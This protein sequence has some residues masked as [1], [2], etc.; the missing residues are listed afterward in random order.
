MKI[1]N[2]YKILLIVLAVFI[3][4]PITTTYA[5]DDS[6]DNFINTMG[7][8]LA[9]ITGGVSILGTGAINNI[10]DIKSTGSCDI[11]HLNECISEAIISVIINISGAIMPA[12]LKIAEFFLNTSINDSMGMGF[13]P[14]N[15]PYVAAGWGVVRNLANAALVIGLVIIAVSI[16]LGYQ[17]NQAKKILLNFIIIALLINFTPVI[18][19]FIIDGTNLLTKSMMTGGINDGYSRSISNL[20]IAIGNSKSGLVN[21]LIYA[22]VVTLFSLFAVVIYFLY[23]LLFFG[24]TV[25]L[26][27]LVIVSP[28]AFATKVFPQSK[29]IRNFFP[30]V[31]YWDDWWES[32]VQWCAIGIPA[33]MSIYLANMMIV[34][35]GTASSTAGMTEGNIFGILVGYSLPF[36]FLLAGFMISISSGGKFGAYVGGVATAVGVGAMS[37]IGGITKT[38]EGWEVKGGAAGAVAGGSAGLMTGMMEGYKGAREGPMGAYDVLK[39]SAKGVVGGAFT[40]KGHAEGKNYWKRSITEAAVDAHLA[41][42]EKLFNQNATIR[43]AAEEEIKNMDFDD[44]KDF[45]KY[46]SRFSE[47]AQGIALGKYLE[48][49]PDILS[50]L[51]GPELSR[52]VNL[53]NRF[54]SKQAKMNALMTLADTNKMGDN[55]NLA[56]ELGFDMNEV[57]TKHN[58]S[59]NEMIINKFNSKDNAKYISTDFIKNPSNLAKMNSNHYSYLA[60]EKGSAGVKIIED[61]IDCN[62]LPEKTLKWFKEQKGAASVYDLKEKIKNAEQ[63]RAQNNPPTP[64]PPPQ[65]NPPTPPP[66]PQNNPPTPQGNTQG[67]PEIG[68]AQGRPEV[69]FR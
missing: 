34:N 51:E 39:G 6:V 54:G 20:F 65:N 59:V 4:M 52:R 21:Q 67:R 9:P 69:N 50:K 18:C 57:A 68:N 36:A 35:I 22:A 27:I 1:T 17:E 2:F 49:S 60:Q 56:K 43:K 44:I 30:G 48:K 15:N 32:F 23:A 8:L 37:K 61:N 66:P 46:G 19:G 33:G 14:D 42:P 7:L 31:T 25:I 58:G 12:L 40:R 16:I 55:N 45:E 41:S 28:I 13:T 62:L 53:L 26:W 63:A 10:I 29:Y 47:E 64:P 11:L 24:R 3:I 38:K 5:A